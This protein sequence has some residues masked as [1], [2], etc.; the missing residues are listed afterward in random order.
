[1]SGYFVLIIYNNNM[2]ILLVLCAMPFLITL[3]WL[4]QR[5]ALRYFVKTPRRYF[6]S[7]IATGITPP[8]L[9]T[10]ILVLSSLRLYTGICYGLSD[11]QNPCTFT[12]FIFDQM[13]WSLYITVPILILNLPASLVVFLLGW[14]TT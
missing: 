10:L 8:I 6:G 5:F 2:V 4:C 7:A 3:D 12:E 13:L 9:V 14:K 11:S 1:M